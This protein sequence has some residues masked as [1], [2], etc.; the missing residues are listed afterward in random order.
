[1]GGEKWVYHPSL[2]VQGSF[3]SQY[4]KDEDKISKLPAYG[5]L[6]F[7]KS[8]DNITA[9]LDFNREKEVGYRKTTPHIAIPSYTYDLF[10]I[11]GEGTGG[12]F[13]A[14]RGDVG[15]IYDHSMSTKSVSDK[16]SLDLGFG[17]VFHGGIDFNLVYANT[18]S[19]QWSDNNVFVANA[20][21]KEN[22]SLYQSVYFKNPGE[23][24]KVDQEF[25]NKI[26]DDKLI[27]VDLSPLGGKNTADIS[28]SRNFSVFKNAKKIATIPFDPG[29]TKT[30]RDK[31]TQVISYFTAAEAKHASLDAG[32]RSYKINSFPT[33][34]CDT[35]FKIVDRIGGYRKSHH[36]SE[37][38]VLGSEGKRHI[39]GIPV[40]NIK[41]R[42]VSF[43]VAKNSGNN[44]T[45]L[46][47]YRVGV[48][49]TPFNK[50]GKDNYYSSE[51]IPAYAHSYLLSGIVSSNYVDVTGDGI[52]EDD[53]GDAVRFNYTRLYGDDNPYQWR[54]PFDENKASYNEGLKT[55]SRDDRGSY[56]YGTKE[57]WMMNSIESK[58]MIATFVLETDTLRKDLFGVKGED[59]GRSTFQPT[60][61]LKKINLYTKADFFKNGLSNAKP[62]KSVHFE[63][64]YELCNGVPSSINTGKLTLKKVWFTYNNN[65]K[66]KLNPYV[67]TYHTY[68]PPFDSKSYDR[69][70]N[71]KNPDDNPGTISNTLTNGEYP[72]SL[73]TGVKGWDSAKAANASSAWNLS[74]IK[75]PSGGFMKVSYESDD[76]AYVQNKRA[77]QMFNI[78]G[79]GTSDTDVL[80]SSLY[81]PEEKDN[82]Y[83]YV[84]VRIPTAVNSIA[85][86]KHRYFEGITKLYFKLFVS[87]P[88]DRWGG[89][90]EQVPCYADFEN[91][92]SN[93]GIKT[94]SSNKI[95]WIKVKSLEDRSPLATA[96]VQ[97]LRINLP[98][99]AF[100]YSEPGDNVSFKDVFGMLSSVAKNITNSVLG[101]EDAARNRNWSNFIDTSKSFV[102]LNSPTY[103]KFGGGHR[104]KQIQLFDNW[105]KMTNQTESSYGQVYDYS[106]SKNINGQDIRISSGVASYE[107]QIGRDENPFCQ[108]IEWVEKMAK[109][110]PTDYVYTDEP[111][112]ESFFPSAQV[113]YSKV[114]VQSLNNTKKS[115]TGKS[116]SEFYTSY[117]FPTLFEFTP[118]DKES[119][120]PF[121]NPIGN[122][123]KIDAKRYI[124]LSQGFKVELNDMH[125]K[126]KSE[127]VYNQNDLKNPISATYYYYK[128]DNPSV[129][130][131]HLKNEVS[132]IDSAN[133]NIQRSSQI[134][135]DIDIIVD[136]REQESKTIF[137]SAQLN[138]DWANPIPLIILPSFPKLPNFEKNRY[139]SI[140]VSKVVN[141][142]GIL[143]SIMHIDK[144]SKVSTSNI[145]YDAES[146]NVLLSRTLNEF[147]D[148]VY[149]FS[150][151]AHWAYEGMSLAY[152]NA[153]AIFKNVNLTGGKLNYKGFLPSQLSRYFQTG[154][155]ILLFGKVKKYNA[156]SPNCASGLYFFMRDTAM[157]IWAIDVSKQNPGNNGI[158][159]IDRNGNPVTASAKSL[160]IIRSGKRNLLDASV[161][162]VTSLSNPVRLVNGAEKIV[163]DSSSIVINSSA[164]TFKDEWQVDSSTYRKD[165][166][167][168]S[169]V[170]MPNS[171]LKSSQLFY[172]QKN[173][174]LYRIHPRNRQTGL[175]IGGKN[176]DFQTYSKEDT[177]TP[178]KTRE[179]MQSWVQFD[180]SSIPR[181]SLIVEANLSLSSAPQRNPAPNV[182]TLTHHSNSKTGTTNESFISSVNGRWIG[183]ALGES[184][185]LQFISNQDYARKYFDHVGLGFGV[186][187]INSQVTLDQTT[188][189][190][191]LEYRY[192]YIN[193]KG[194]TQNMLNQYYS[195][196]GVFKPSINISLKNFGICSGRGFSSLAYAYDSCQFLTRNINNEA[197]AYGPFICKPSLSVCYISPCSDGS[198]P[199]SSSTTPP[200]YYCNGELIDSSICV[201]N[202]TDS[203]VNPYRWG[204]WGNWQ[205]D[206]AYV[207][208]SNRKDSNALTTTNIR[209]DGQ[210]LKF[211]PYWKFSNSY[212][213]ASSD[214]TRWVWN[215]EIN[216]INSKGLQLQNKDPLG[217]HNAV[218]YGYHQTLPIAVAQNSK[219][220]EMGFDGFEDYGYRTDTCKTCP[221]NRFMKMQSTGT[222]VDSISHTGLYSLRINPNDSN[223]VTFAVV[224]SI[225]DTSNVVVIS[226]TDSSTNN[227]ATI[228]GKGK[229]LNATYY[230][231]SVFPSSNWNICNTQIDT[232]INF[233]WGTSNPS[234]NCYSSRKRVIW[235]GYIQPR[236]SEIYRFHATADNRMIVNLNG[237]RISQNNP[238]ES[239]PGTYDLDT[240]T[241]TAGKL[242]PMSVE[243]IKS[244]PNSNMSAILE[245][246]SVSEPRSV[247]PKSQ[248][249]S[250]LSQDTTGSLISGLVNCLQIKNPKP[251]NVVLPNFSPVQN[252]KIV[253]SAW[254][255]EKNN[256][257]DSVST[258]RNTE[259]K[260][261]FSSGLSRTLK[262]TG[263]IIE[264][265]QRIEDTLTIPSGVNSI[266]VIMKSTNYG[267]PVY[268]DDIR[269]HPYNSNL[270]SYVY[271][272]INIRLMA[273]L[274]ENN[275][276]TFY[277]YDDDGTL[278]RV[279]KETERGIKTINETR[280][281]LLRD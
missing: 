221:D 131:L 166:M 269:I 80:H 64:S 195:T 90:F 50:S 35:N 139:R 54:A 178:N 77:M 127:S 214:S 160:R 212:L 259:I 7:D 75:M 107:P 236:F 202:I 151:P 112:G 28:A 141:R 234:P 36:I 271:N 243:L 59:G 171:C 65:K 163:F 142:Y 204:I 268:F 256:T 42:D 29:T 273:E 225:A 6:Y 156:N 26:G 183:D 158:Y 4:I 245:W 120:K 102:R 176:P 205:S 194:L 51:D 281:V 58:T 25:Y 123:F 161:G 255:K 217:R 260:V 9:L 272:P 138:V 132:T 126:P 209:K 122:I 48:D 174:S 155:E 175:F 38:Q 162:S 2:F 82:D 159:F 106:T 32:I 184:N 17:Q 228:N 146:G 211:S 189:G 124:T 121:S 100:P 165:T 213:N 265:W 137:A 179:Y 135:K 251:S 279:K 113:G 226:E 278:I 219:S 73:Q 128:V 125:G 257:P 21:F 235:S 237:R 143:D 84:F 154:D 94:G 89:G 149:N 277:E 186:L 241:L 118:L 46:V 63:Y 275:F 267:I 200:L 47:A 98:S 248:L 85:E 173:Y 52:T 116:V 253:I 67:F 167:V 78:V 86:L 254:V 92:S 220:R 110:G 105:N 144:G 56:T 229:G 191:F 49:N 216:L 246:S 152:K 43:S 222:L 157:R 114:T 130:S 16:L 232:T 95:I 96:A 242:Y 208:Y 24:T 62:I 240:M 83:F 39:Y 71:Y 61:R 258:Y 264:G 41:Q 145:V 280:S 88:A 150:Y 140:A 153:D 270:K 55:D 193:V 34:S 45:G 69:W 199:F 99:K 8:V 13:R 185:L 223:V 262:P 3:S 44:E 168:R 181:G 224:P 57:V 218:Q 33:I 87:M 31:R 14:F 247:I 196:N 30:Q 133:G 169:K 74:T 231:S 101:F 244:T 230:R 198:T 197:N 5:Y 206:R 188:P 70:G 60:L 190:A 210:I 117:D 66:G 261:L 266:S 27:R 37:I 93:F 72:Y 22:D 109:L 252:S 250:S 76:Y 40:Y 164:M 136:V 97:F 274:D 103:S 147:D 207:Y 129:V 18:R 19:G 238:I 249:Y 68:N 108:P 91:N 203:S 201:P 239:N 187:D 192:D 1:V 12:M 10:S 182:Y 180:L 115:A 233:N 15:Y 134:G 215:S 170:L 227:I 148:F 20:K 53:N 11:T 177:C 81:E 23:K 111:L 104:V 276:A 172:A 263:N 79:L 119:R